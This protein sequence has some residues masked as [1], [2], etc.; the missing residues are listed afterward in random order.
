MSI[1]QKLHL[2]AEKDSSGGTKT[3]QSSLAAGEDLPNDVHKIE[4]R[5]SYARGTSSTQVKA[6]AGF[7]H[8]INIHCTTTSGSII[9]YDN[10]AAAGNIV[11]EIPMFSS[12]NFC[13]IYDVS[14]GSG[15]YMSQNATFTGSWSVS[16]R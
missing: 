1:F 2:I 7:L 6:V 13:G 3:S 14:L 12:G 11:D 5:Y 15:L 9:V 10:P 4:H 16:Y 8:T